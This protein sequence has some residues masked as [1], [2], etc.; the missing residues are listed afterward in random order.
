ML[1][2]KAEQIAAEQPFKRALELT[3][4][5]LFLATDADASGMVSCGEMKESLRNGTM[6]RIERELIEAQV[7]TADD[8]HTLKLGLF[9]LGEDVALFDN[10][11]AELNET[12]FSI[13]VLRAHRAGMK[14][15]WQSA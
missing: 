13:G 8:A 12:E 10:P 6:E 9:E 7:L 1:Q 5:R 4:Q 3:M 11:D 14:R 15:L 2:E